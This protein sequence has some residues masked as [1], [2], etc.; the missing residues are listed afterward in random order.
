MKPLF[1]MLVVAGFLGS[2]SRKPA[3][4][5]HVWFIESYDNGVITVQHDGNTYK[6][7][8]SGR[9]SYSSDFKDV[10]TL[11]NCGNA[12]ELVQHSVQPFGGELKREAD[13]RTLVILNVGSRLVLRSTKDEHS[14]L[15]DEEFTITSVTKTPH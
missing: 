1:S 15:I 8:C 2:C 13:G 9:T 6:A 12:V 5:P 10:T 4:D 7:T 3:L 14:P 11:P